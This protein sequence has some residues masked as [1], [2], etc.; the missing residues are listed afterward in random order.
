M[1]LGVLEDRAM[2]HVPGTTQYYDDPERPQYAADGVTGLK[3]DTSGPVP[4]ILVPQPSDDP[5]DPLNWP[6]WKR[7]LITLILSL[8]AIFGTA[9]G[10]ILAANTITLSLWLKVKFTKVA[11]LTGYFLLGVGVGGFFFVPS[12]RIWGKRHA[13]LIGTM[14]LIGTSAWGGATGHNYKSLLWA[15]IIQGIGAAPFEA[16]V[17]ATVGDLYFVHVSVL[18][19]S[20]IVAN[21]ATSS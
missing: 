14:I 4:I 8:T 20:A 1:G 17:N 2:E 18:A 13:F 5:N 7:D 11:L 12:S 9:L 19:P 6:L 3:M 21:S 16:L 10:P 15:R